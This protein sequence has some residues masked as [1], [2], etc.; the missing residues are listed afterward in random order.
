MNT[1]NNEPNLFIITQETE[2]GKKYFNGQDQI[3]YSDLAN[4]TWASKNKEAQEIIPH[5]K[6]PNSKVEVIKESDF[7]FAANR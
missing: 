5:F 4:A 3:F 1:Q 6:L 2:D 7:V